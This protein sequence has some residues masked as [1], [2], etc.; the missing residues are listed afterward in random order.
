MKTSP[1]GIALIKEFEGLRARPYLCSAQVATIGYGSTFYADGSKVELSDPVISTEQAEELLA[2]TLGQYEDCVNQ[3]SDN[4][5]Q[6]QF[7]ALVCF[8]YNLGCRALTGSTLAKLV[9]AGDFNNAAHAF[10]AWNKS[11]GKVLPGLVRR[12]AAEKNLFQGAT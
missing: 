11:G 7:D 9:R 2:M 1:K 8:A 12:R 3:L 10:A 5:D 6:N 4:L